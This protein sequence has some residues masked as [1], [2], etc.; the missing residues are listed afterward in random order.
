[1][2][3]YDRV[4]CEFSGIMTLYVIDLFTV[5]QAGMRLGFDEK[6]TLEY[7]MFKGTGEI[8]GQLAHFEPFRDQG[9]KIVLGMGL[10]PMTGKGQRAVYRPFEDHPPMSEEAVYAAIQKSTKIFP[11]GDSMAGRSLPLS[12][13]LVGKEF[14]VRYDHGGPVWNYRFDELRKLRWRSEGDAQWHEE[15]YE[16]YEPDEGMIFFSH[17][18]SGTRLPECKKIV[19]DFTNG[20]TTCV[21]SKVGS[22]Y[23]AN[24]VSYQIIFG[25]I[26]M[27]GLEAPGYLRHTFTDELVGHAYTWNYG[28]N[29]TSMHVYSTPHSYSWTIFTDNGALGLQ[30]SSPSQYVKLREDVYLFTWVEEAC[31]GGQGT[32]L[33]NTK[34]MHDSGFGFSGGKDGLTLNTIGAYARHAGYYDVKKFF[35]GDGPR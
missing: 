8:V 29:L 14:T 20:L 2:Y 5:T 1:M 21:N 23:M 17:L 13:F 12:D 18:H 33:I 19:L 26:E 15:V 16:A 30:W 34:T 22:K 24:E 3:I 25:V 11:A 10:P 7:C 32:I 28:E 9:E 4:E 31:N 27:K 35:N 6:D